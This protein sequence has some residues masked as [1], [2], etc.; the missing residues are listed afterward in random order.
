MSITPHPSGLRLP[1]YADEK[2]DNADGDGGGDEAITEPGEPME[3][4]A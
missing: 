4:P 2:D 1:L 3:E